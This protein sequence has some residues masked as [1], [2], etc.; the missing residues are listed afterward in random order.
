[1]LAGA[2]GCALGSDC[3]DC[4]PATD[5]DGDGYAADPL[6]LA[7]F[8]DCDD[9]NPSINKGA[10]DTSVD[11]VDQNCDGVDGPTDIFGSSS[12][13]S[14]SGGSTGGSTTGGTTTG[15]G[16]QVEVLQVEVL[17]PVVLQEMEQLWTSPVGLCEDTKA[18]WEIISM[19]ELVMTIAVQITIPF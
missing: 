4:G 9:N 11:G 6:G 14:T 10:P 3:T 13:G 1:M 7:Y 16:L 12:G 5:M 17:Q 8:S 19:M 18:S 2:V 15:G